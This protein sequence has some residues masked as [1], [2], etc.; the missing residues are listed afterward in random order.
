MEAITTSADGSYRLEGLAPSATY[1]VE[2]RARGF[3][4]HSQTVDLSADLQLDFTLEVGRIQEM[5]GPL[6]EVALRLSNEQKLTGTG[7]NGVFTH[8][9]VQANFIH[10]AS[11]RRAMPTMARAASV[12]V[13]PWIGIPNTLSDGK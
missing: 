7:V 4:I 10:A 6:I 11:P 2:V 5:N 13:V 12:S 1:G 8:P 9:A 3:A